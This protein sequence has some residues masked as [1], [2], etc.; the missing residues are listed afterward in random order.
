[1]QSLRISKRSRRFRPITHRQNKPINIKRKK[2]NKLHK[3]EKGLE[4]ELEPKSKQFIPDLNAR[5]LSNATFLRLY[6]YKYSENEFYTILKKS[7]TFKCFYAFFNH[8]LGNL[9]EQLFLILF[10]SLMIST[11][12]QNSFSFREF[13]KRAVPNIDV[14]QINDM[15]DAMTE[16]GTGLSKIVYEEC[17]MLKNKKIHSKMSNV[18]STRS[19]ALHHRNPIR[20]GGRRKIHKTRTNKKYIQTGGVLFLIAELITVILEIRRRLRRSNDSL[21]DRITPFLLLLFFILEITAQFSTIDYFEI[22]P[23]GHRALGNITPL[24]ELPIGNLPSFIAGASEFIQWLINDVAVAAAEEGQCLPQPGYTPSHAYQTTA[25][26]GAEAWDIV[27]GDILISQLSA[28]PA[29]ETAFELSPID[30]EM[31]FSAFQRCLNLPFTE[32]NALRIAELLQNSQSEFVI[33]GSI[34]EVPAAEIQARLDPLIVALGSAYENSI[35]GT[36]VQIQCATSEGRATQLNDDLSLDWSRRQFAMAE[37]QAFNSRVGYFRLVGTG[38]IVLSSDY[39]RNIL[40]RIF[41]FARSLFIT[42][43]PPLAR[44][45]GLQDAARLPSIFPGINRFASDRAS[46]AES[47][48]HRPRAM[49]PDSAASRSGFAN[50]PSYGSNIARAAADIEIDP[51]A[52]A[53]DNLGLYQKYDEFGNALVSRKHNQ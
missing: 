22:G 43:P 50:Q 8:V 27:T 14:A 16:I 31:T 34:L 44:Q 52:D 29:L 2:L 45:M 26:Q 32:R 48:R 12:G 11:S 39:A 15:N 25:A 6:S 35:G 10:L 37:E 21:L 40:R 33:P 49:S 24:E 47:L 19:A 42:P 23:G 41:Y 3:L 28:I 1:M 38:V 17:F 7:K 30:A 5:V 4:P 13:I 53:M 18:R 51:L 36:G 46:A 20:I 9:D